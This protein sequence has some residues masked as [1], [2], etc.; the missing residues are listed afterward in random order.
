MSFKV[1]I[2]L[3]RGGHMSVRKDILAVRK[4]FKLIAI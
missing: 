3:W 4:V 2:F 1:L